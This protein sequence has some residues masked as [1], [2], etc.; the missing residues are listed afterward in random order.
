MNIR[1]DKR[2]DDHSRSADLPGIDARAHS[3]NITPDHHDIF[4]GA[5]ASREKHLDVRSFEHC[6]TDQVPGGNA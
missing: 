3:S 2:V 1:N 5:N 4:S 6:I